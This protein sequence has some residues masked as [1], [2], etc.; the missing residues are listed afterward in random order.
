MRF[1]RS[2]DQRQILSQ[3]SRERRTTQRASHVP[4]GFPHA[5][6]SFCAGTVGL[7]RCVETVKRVMIAI[8]CSRT[9]SEQGT[10]PP[11]PNQ[12]GVKCLM[13]NQLYSYLGC[14]D[15]QRTDK[16]YELFSRFIIPPVSEE[17]EN[18]TGDGKSLLSTTGRCM[19]NSNPGC[20]RG[21]DDRIRA[22]SSDPDTVVG[23]ARGLCVIGRGVLCHASVQVIEEGLQVSRVLQV[24]Q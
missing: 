4:S 5:F 20:A 10:Q 6:H 12:S 8:I 2:R 24:A 1:V 15:E 14:I 13:N 7:W 16:R 23:Y 11:P 9:K 17:N 18:M 21:N 22:G 3:I 19:R